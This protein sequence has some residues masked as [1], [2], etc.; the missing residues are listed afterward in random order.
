MGMTTKLTVTDIQEINRL[1]D[2]GNTLAYLGHKYKLDPSSISRYIWNPRRR[3]QPNIINE[4]IG[5]AIHLLRNEL[6]SV[7]R[8]AKIMGI[9]ESVVGNYLRS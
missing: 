8:I 3:G 9:S 4:E 7:P 2:D 5:Q 6:H 1:Y